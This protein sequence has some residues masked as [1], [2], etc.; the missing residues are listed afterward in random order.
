MLIDSLCSLI[1]IHLTML[2]VWNLKYICDLVEMES[3]YIH[4]VFLLLL[5]LVS[6]WLKRPWLLPMLVPVYLLLRL[7]WW[8]RFDYTLSLIHI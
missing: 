6:S 3:D 8:T 7:L 4:T 1:V 5:L 2:Y